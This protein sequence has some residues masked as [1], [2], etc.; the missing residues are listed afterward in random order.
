[1]SP[2]PFYGLSRVKRAFALHK[3]GHGLLGEEAGEF[4]MDNALPFENS[5]PINEMTMVEIGEALENVT[6]WIESERVRERDARKVFE[7]VSSE[8]EA[9]VAK[10]RGYAEKLLR[11]NRDKMSAFDGLLGVKP[12]PQIGQNKLSRPSGNSPSLGGHAPQY[13]QEPKNLGEAILSVW[14]LDRYAEPLTTD[15]LADAVRDVGYETSAAPT[16]LKSSI[17]Q[18]L[19]KL[20]KVGRVIRYR[21]DGSMIDSKDRTSRARKYLAATRLPEGVIAE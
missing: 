10:I 18:A 20:C 14:Q 2:R 3:P 4:H 7:T 6:R 13:I 21:A 16:S 8:V 5:K 15:E 1:M 11:A 17:N 19:A 12:Q 9:K